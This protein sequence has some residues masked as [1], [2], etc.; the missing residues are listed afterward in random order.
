MNLPMTVEAVTIYLGI[1]LAGCAV[2]SIADSFAADEVGWGALAMLLCRAHPC[3]CDIRACCVQCRARQ[4]QLAKLACMHPTC[5]PMPPASGQDEPDRQP[6]SQT[7]SQTDRQPPQP[8]TPCTFLPSQP[9]L[10]SP[11]ATGALQAAHRRRQGHLHSGRG[12]EGGQAAA[13][14]CTRGRGRRTPCHRAAQ[15]AWR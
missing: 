7:D 6:D 5:T 12:A 4:R 9:H 10:D 13:A 8:C 3:L 2:V 15:P 14:V 1:V 11:P